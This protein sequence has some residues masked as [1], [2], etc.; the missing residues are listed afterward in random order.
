M[1]LIL[2]FTISLIVLIGLSILVGKYLA[3]IIK[4]DFEN[5]IKEL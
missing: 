3:Q 5:E 1:T 2:T 4:D